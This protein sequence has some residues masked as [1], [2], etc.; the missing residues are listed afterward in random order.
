MLSTARENLI[1]GI[2]LFKISCIC[3]RTIHENHQLSVAT[4]LPSTMAADEL[5]ETTADQN[6]EGSESYNGSNEDSAVSMQIDSPKVGGSTGI[7]MD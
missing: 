3:F 4:A 5:T 2:H 1:S 7:S 6:L